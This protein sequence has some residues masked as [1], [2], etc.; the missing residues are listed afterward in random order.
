M[1]LYLLGDG[2]RKATYIYIYIPYKPA[3]VHQIF[4]ENIWLGD[5]APEEETVGS[6]AMYMVLVEVNFF[7]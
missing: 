7:A 6:A 3:Y 4:A 1:D 5:T 2:P